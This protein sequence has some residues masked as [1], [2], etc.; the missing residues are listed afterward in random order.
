MKL[1]EAKLSLHT[2]GRIYIY[3]F[4][5]LFIYK[6]SISGE[7]GAGKSSTINLFL[8]CQLLPTDALKC[9]NTIL[10][11]R[12][13]TDN[14]KEAVCYYRGAEFQDKRKVIKLSMTFVVCFCFIFSFFP[15]KF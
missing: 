1:M 12:C 5:Y 13:S 10:E 4:I 14:R 9:T 8:G 7:V 3:L 2:S 15:G 6:A 11:I